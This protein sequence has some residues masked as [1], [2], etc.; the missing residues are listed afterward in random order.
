[1][2]DV[3]EIS[4]LAK[5]Y[6]ISEEE[7]RSSAKGVFL[8]NYASL[9]HRSD[10]ET[11][12]RKVDMSGGVPIEAIYDAVLV[13]CKKKG[14]DTPKFFY[15]TTN[16]CASEWGIKEPHMAPEDGNLVEIKAYLGKQAFKVRLL[17]T[18]YAKEFCA[19]IG[20]ATDPSKEVLKGIFKR[21][22]ETYPSRV[23]VFA[24]TYRGTPIGIQDIGVQ[25]P[26]TDSFCVNK[27]LTNIFRKASSFDFD[28][29]VEICN[30]DSVRWLL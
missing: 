21:I 4:T 19:D 27:N 26:R 24:Q 30:D 20:D 9:W 14:Y 22:R 11:P 1:M 5:N 25:L 6:G 18:K 8:L 15:A 23:D 2:A 7:L 12:H 16:L 13:D 10:T 17:D 29:L 28:A 3:D